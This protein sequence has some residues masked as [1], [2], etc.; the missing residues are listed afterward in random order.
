ML[1][2]E[3]ATIEYL[4][5]CVIEF[6]VLEPDADLYLPARIIN[7]D[8]TVT[9]TRIKAND[10]MFY[11]EYGSV[12][13]PGAFL[14][15]KCRLYA[16][17]LIDEVFSELIDDI[18]EN[19][20]GVDYAKSKIREMCLKIQDRVRNELRR[21]VTKTNVLNRALGQPEENSRF[22]VDLNELASYVRCEAKF[23][24]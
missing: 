24:N 23:K 13:V 5:D 6:G 2:K 16:D 10:A 19:G 22:V 17:R 15:E 9:N 14:L 4:S 1:S 3:L 18:V 21:Y 20:Q 11:V 12:S 8:G 7:T